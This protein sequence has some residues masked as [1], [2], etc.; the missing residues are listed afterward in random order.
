MSGA[1]LA[2]VA[3]GD[4]SA[5]MSDPP[6]D[7]ERPARWW[8]REVG[9]RTRGESRDCSRTATR[10]ARRRGKA[11]N[12]KSHRGLSCRVVARCDS[13]CCH[14]LEH[15]DELTACMQEPLPS[16]GCCVTACK[17][18]RHSRCASRGCCDV[19][20]TRE[21]RQRQVIPGFELPVVARCDVAPLPA[22][23]PGVVV[24]PLPA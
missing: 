10:I 19:S 4:V 21:S 5:A 11:G 15:Q 1:V 13:V 17:T 6:R 16:R 20:P 18:W 22:R 9:E 23:M 3:E 12:G 24:M 8:R 7:A 2:T 14:W